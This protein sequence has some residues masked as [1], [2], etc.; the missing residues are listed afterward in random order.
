MRIISVLLSMRHGYHGPAR[1]RK[2]MFRL[3]VLQPF[4]QGKPQMMAETW[5]HAFTNVDATERP[6][7]WV[8]CLDKLHAEPFYRE[9]KDRVRAI[10]SPRVGNLYLELGAGVGTDA[11]KLGAKVIAVD[12]SLTMCRETQARGRISCVAAD[13]HA[14]P[15]RSD[16]ADGCWSDRTFQ[17]LADPERALRELTRVT[18]AGSTIVVVDPDYGTQAMPFPDQPLADRVTAFR[19]HHLLRNGTLAHRMSELFVQVGL[20]DVSV[21]EKRL[22]VRDPRSMDNVLG[23]RTWARTA[24]ERGIMEGDEAERWESLYDQVVAGGKFLWSVSFFITSG[25]KPP[26]FE[27]RQP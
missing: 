12:R 18:K 8:A 2:Q 5:Q 26:L 27:E 4:G 3:A 13:A 14:L 11:I 9:Y 1:R 16:L 10:L 24:A 22:I 7:D 23:L 25:R 17:H 15:F 20:R 21:E 19:A 6:A